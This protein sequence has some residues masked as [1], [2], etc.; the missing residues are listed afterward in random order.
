MQNKYI[1][2]ER[3][4]VVVPSLLRV[5]ALLGTLSHVDTVRIQH[6]LFGTAHFRLSGQVLEELQ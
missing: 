4:F 5:H 6:R 2:D 1:T 3:C